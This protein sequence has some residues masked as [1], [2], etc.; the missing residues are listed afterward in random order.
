[1]RGKLKPWY[2]KLRNSEFRYIVNK[3]QL[4]FWG[5]TR[6]ITFDICS[7]L[8]YIVNRTKRFD[9]LVHYIE[10]WVYIQFT[11][12]TVSRNK[13]ISKGKWHSLLPSLSIISH[14]SSMLNPQLSSILFKASS[15]VGNGSCSSFSSL[16]S[17]TPLEYSKW[18]WI[19]KSI[20]NYKKIS[21]VIWT[22]YRLKCN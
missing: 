21:N 1:M 13:L 17:L 5:F 3:T 7:E 20:E 19:Y 6:H 2:N 15:R 4:P 14:F 11:L 10:V 12:R 16:N 18:W 9:G 8:F 22:E